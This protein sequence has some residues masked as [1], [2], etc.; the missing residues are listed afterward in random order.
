MHEYH[1]KEYRKVPELFNEFVKQCNITRQSP[2]DTDL[3]ISTLEIKFK[4][5]DIHT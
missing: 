5:K 4:F 2:T 1:S 3:Q